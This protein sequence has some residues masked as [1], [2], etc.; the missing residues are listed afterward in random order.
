MAELVFIGHKHKVTNRP[1]AFA[2]SVRH[3]RILE[4]FGS[5]PEGVQ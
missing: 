3:K 1:P 2:P 4:G 5:E